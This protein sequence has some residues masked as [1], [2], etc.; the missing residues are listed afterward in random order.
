MCSG[1]CRRRTARNLDL[2][3]RRRNPRRFSSEKFSDYV[4]TGR[5][6]VLWWE[7]VDEERQVP[8]SEHTVIMSNSAIG[9]KYPFIAMGDG[10]ERHR[11]HVVRVTAVTRAV[12]IS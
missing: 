9:Q 8:S 12:T 10:Y 5:Q 3:L 6:I 4:R 7:Q 11:K 2:F 1:C